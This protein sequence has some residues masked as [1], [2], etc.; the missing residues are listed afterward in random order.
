MSL[1]PTLQLDRD[2]DERL[3]KAEA[4][5][6]LSKLFTLINTDDS[7]CKIDVDELLQLLDELEV[8]WDYQLA[9]K[10]LLD[11]VCE[12]FSELDLLDNT[13]CSLRS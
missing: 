8:P 3:T 5:D 6:F 4:L 2:T 10:M 9:V 13:H 7:D 12:F 1:K 11:Q